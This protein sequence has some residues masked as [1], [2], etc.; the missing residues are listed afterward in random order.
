MV[1]EDMSWEMFEERFWEMYLA[2]EFID[3]QLNDFN[4]L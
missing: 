4:A 2:K 3:R 1:V